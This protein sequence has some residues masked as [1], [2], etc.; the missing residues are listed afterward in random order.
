MI[1]YLHVAVIGTSPLKRRVK[2]KVGEG[3]T[4]E[5]LLNLYV[6]KYKAGDILG[7]MTGISVL[8]NGARGNFKQ[9]LQDGD[10]IKVI[11]PLI[12]G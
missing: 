6:E 1:I 2:M 8:I 10:K 3:T 7:N 11:K 12:R 5:A 9:E 4:A